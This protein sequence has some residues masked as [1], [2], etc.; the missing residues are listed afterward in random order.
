MGLEARISADLKA[1]MKAGDKVRLE[2][3]RMLRAQI[4]EFQKKGL[5]REMTEEDEL[6]ILSTAVKRRKESIEQF[7]AGG[8]MDLVEKET[9]ELRIVSEYLPEQL[10]DAEAEAI[11]D[12]IVRESGATS[13]REMGKVM[14]LALKELKGKVDAKRISELVKSKLTG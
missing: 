12:R 1:A 10:S 14:P 13:P 7:Q 4:I 3:L 2:T 5:G 6:S 9:N 8:R 11:V